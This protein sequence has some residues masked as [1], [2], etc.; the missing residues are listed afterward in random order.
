MS[1]EIAGA[2]YWSV[3][4]GRWET[5]VPALPDYCADLLAPPI[6]VGAAPCGTDAIAALPS[7]ARPSESG[8]TALDRLDMLVPFPRETP[9]AATA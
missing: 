2:A 1:D 8:P 9:V 6:L 5:L 7:L 4:E 3:D